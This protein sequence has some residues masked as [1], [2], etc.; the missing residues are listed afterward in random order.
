[1]IGFSFGGFLS[2]GVD[3]FDMQV[4]L[5]FD[6]EFGQKFKFNIDFYSVNS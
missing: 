3:R 1:M 2:G 6:R 5:W 4:L